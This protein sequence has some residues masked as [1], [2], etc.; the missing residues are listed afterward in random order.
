MEPVKEFLLTALKREVE[1][2]QN[3]GEEPVALD[4]F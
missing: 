1:D 3:E 4:A 2:A